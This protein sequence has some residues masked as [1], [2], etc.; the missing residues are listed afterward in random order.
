MLSVNRAF[1]LRAA[2]VLATGACGKASGDRAHIS[3]R[4]PTRAASYVGYEYEGVLPN[5]TMPNGVLDAGGALIGKVGDTSFALSF[6]SH[7]AT[8]MLWLEHAIGGANGHIRWHVDAVLGLPTL[9]HGQV[10]VW[11][12]S[13][14]VTGANDPELIV[15]VV[16]TDT[17]R[18]TQIVR[19][20]RADRRHHTFREIGTRGITCEN[21]GY[22][23]D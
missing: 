11:G 5:D 20:W 8:K 23:A 19:A 2:C 10:F 14:A 3:T 16:D 22:G 12:A 17:E 13:C 4:E 6:L 7:D 1:I 18:Y 21:E 15:A 9:P